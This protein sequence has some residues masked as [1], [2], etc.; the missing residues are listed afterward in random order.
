MKKQPCVKNCLRKLFY[1]RCFSKKWV[2]ISVEDPDTKDPHYFARSGSE[3]FSK[4]PEPYMII[5][6]FPHFSTPPSQLIPSPFVPHPFTLVPHY[7]SLTPQPLPFLLHNT[8]LLLIPPPS[9]LTPY[10]SS[11]TSHLS[12]SSLIPH[13]RAMN[14]HSFFVDADLADFQNGDPD[15]AAFKMWIWIQIQL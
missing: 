5:A 7:T 15:P 8:S 3:I 1:F 4:D 2:L 13:P 6:Y 9:S 11:C 14:P 12:S 10:P